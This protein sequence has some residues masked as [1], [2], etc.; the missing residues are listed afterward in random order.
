MNIEMMWNNICRHEGELFYTKTNKEYD[1]VVKD[2]YILVRNDSLKKIKRVDF[3][4]A[5]KINNPT[6]A[7]I[8]SEGIWGP[9]Y[10]LGIITDKRIIAYS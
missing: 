6:R 9:S 2:N 4:K 8:E 7:K 10:V 5:L 1:Y 3:E